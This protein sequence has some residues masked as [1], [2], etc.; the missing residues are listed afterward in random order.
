MHSAS[1]RAR[2]QAQDNQN[3]LDQVATH[4]EMT[5]M[6]ERKETATREDTPTFSRFVH[7]D[8]G[9]PG[10]TQGFDR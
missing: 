2:K 3:Q 6:L 1:I 7:Y 4:L 5:S 8:G 9:K 10:S